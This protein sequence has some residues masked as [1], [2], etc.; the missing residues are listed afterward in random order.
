MRLNGDSG[1]KNMALGSTFVI[2][3]ILLL[4][5]FF[6]V[7]FSVINI[8]T[9]ITFAV[10]S[11]ISLYFSISAFLSG[12]ATYYNYIKNNHSSER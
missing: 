1:I 9:T 10:A 11:S 2:I 8:L 5:N 4:I 3:N 12:F 7:S 6:I